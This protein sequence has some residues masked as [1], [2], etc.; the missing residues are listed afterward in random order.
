MDQVKAFLEQ[1]RAFDMD[2]SGRLGEN[3]IAMIRQ[4]LNRLPSQMSIATRMGPY[5]KSQL[6]A[7]EVSLSLCACSMCGNCLVTRFCSKC[8]EPVH[9]APSLQPQ[10]HMHGV[11]LGSPAS[12]E[13]R[14]NRS[15]CAPHKVTDPKKPSLH[16]HISGNSIS[17]QVELAK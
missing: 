13:I 6:V 9:V 3:D 15:E 7:A 11:S 4:G 16:V 5:R 8:G 10:A 17:D 1:F 12:S 2:G 14:E